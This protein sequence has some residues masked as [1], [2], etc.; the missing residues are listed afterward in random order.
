MRLNAAT[1]GAMRILMVCRTDRPLSMPEMAR[2]LGL[3]EALVLKTCNELMQA[4]YLVG[5]RGPGGGYR[6]AKP[7]GAIN[8]VEIL[9]L[10]EPQENLFPCRLHQ[11]DECRIV[12]LC[13]LRRACEAAYRAFREELARLSL[14]DLAL[15]TAEE[16]GVQKAARA[17]SQ[18]AAGR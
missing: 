14:A 10:F 13:I 6:L 15:D 1:N 12:S 11:E 9:D 3:T 18:A 4:G 5:Q 16:G 7:A 17:S 2:R 8:A